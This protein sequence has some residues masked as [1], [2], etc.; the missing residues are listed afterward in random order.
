MSAFALVVAINVSTLQERVSFF[1]PFFQ[2]AAFSTVLV[3]NGMQIVK[4]I[5]EAEDSE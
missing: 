5:K 4:S 2:V 3:N 1:V